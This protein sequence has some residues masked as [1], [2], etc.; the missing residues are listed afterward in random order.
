MDQKELVAYL[1]KLTGLDKTTPIVEPSPPEDPLMALLNERKRQREPLLKF[2]KGLT[3][4]SLLLLVGMI[5]CQGTARL[6]MPDFSI[7]SGNEFEILVAGVFGEIIGLI[8]VIVKSLWD[9]TSY[10]DYLK[11]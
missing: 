9:D 3:I 8:Y 5:V 4:S 2:I 7:F 6:W 10:L 11:K 1:Q